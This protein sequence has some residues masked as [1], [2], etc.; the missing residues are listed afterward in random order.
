MKALHSFPS[1]RNLPL[2]AIRDHLPKYAR[3]LYVLDFVTKEE[4][5]VW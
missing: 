3:E 1:R 5:I 4:G 2:L